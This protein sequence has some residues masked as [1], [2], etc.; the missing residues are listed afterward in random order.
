MYWTYIVVAQRPERKAKHPNLRED[1]FKIIPVQ[2]TQEPPVSFV[3]H[4]FLFLPMGRLYYLNHR[5]T[6]LQDGGGSTIYNSVPK[7]FQKR[8]KKNN[9][10]NHLPFKRANLGH[11]L[12]WTT[13]AGRIKYHLWYSWSSCSVSSALQFSTSIYGITIPKTTLLK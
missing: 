12:T 7:Y 1:S 8:L 5:W 13:M 10:Q 3:C 2:I 6:S 9:F 11:F 4:W